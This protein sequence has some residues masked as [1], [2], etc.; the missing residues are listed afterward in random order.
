MDER[1]VETLNNSVVFAGR[2]RASV[3]DLDKLLEDRSAFASLHFDPTRTSQLDR[4]E[5]NALVE[6]MARGGFLLVVQ[7]NYAYMPRFYRQPA[8]DTLFDFLATELPKRNSKFRAE[9]LAPT[10]PIFQ[11]PYEINVP[12][13]I[14]REMELDSYVGETAFFYEDRM[15]GYTY[16]LYGFEDDEGFQPLRRP[17]QVYTLMDAGYRMLENIYHYALSH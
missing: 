7:N 17:F 16:A 11:G 9:R 14:A 5:Q 3:T 2:L 1:L 15:V 10:H 6:F 12:P 8:R 13:A 4:E